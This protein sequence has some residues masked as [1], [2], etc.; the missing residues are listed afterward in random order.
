MGVI[1]KNLKF[2][3]KRLTALL[4]AG[5]MVL[6]SGCGKMEEKDECKIITPYTLSDTL[7]VT[8]PDATLDIAKEVYINESMFALQYEHKDHNHYKSLISGDIYSTN[9]CNIDEASYA[10]FPII[11]AGKMIHYSQLSSKNISDYLTEEE[12][13]KIKNNEFTKTDEDNAIKRIL[14]SAVEL[15][16]STENIPDLVDNDIVENQADD[17]VE[18]QADDIVEN[19]VNDINEDVK[20]YDLEKLYVSETLSPFSESILPYI[21]LQTDYNLDYYKEYHGNFYLVDKDSL[22]AYDNNFQDWNQEFFISSSIKPLSD[23]LTEEEIKNSKNGQLTELQLDSIL[24]KI[25]NDY[26]Q[27]AIENDNSKNLTK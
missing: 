19:Q 17:I 6:F 15:E 11:S 4:L 22:A 26:K 18:N 2:N 8:R 16:K 10:Y 20:T 9:E 13:L 12:L 25:R 1:M 7:V 5:N 27:Q 21:F 14:E 3:K 23:Y 24:A